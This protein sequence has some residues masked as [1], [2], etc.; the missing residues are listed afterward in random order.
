[1]TGVKQSH[2]NSHKQLGNALNVLP[3]ILK[4]Y[5]KILQLQI[6]FPVISR[7]E[8]QGTFAFAD[9]NS[10]GQTYI[11]QKITAQFQKKSTALTD[12]WILRNRLECFFYIQQKKRSF[13]F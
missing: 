13:P 4:Y 2:K 5:C 10:F 12:R 6:S 7:I 9:K 8:P 11:L 3:I 1:M